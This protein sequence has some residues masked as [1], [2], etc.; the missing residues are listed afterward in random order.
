MRD[1]AGGQGGGDPGREARDA[2]AHAALLHRLALHHGTALAA[3]AAAGARTTGG[4]L[5][6][7]LPDLAG[8][9]AAADLA[10]FARDATERMVLCLETLWQRGNHA[11]DRGADGLKPLLAF[12]FDVVLDGRSLPRPTN[13]ALVLIRPPEGFPPTRPGGRPW[14]IIDPRAGHGSG[15]GGSKAESEVGAALRDGHPVYFVIFHPDPAPDQTLADVC[16]AEARFLAEIRARHPGA[17]PPLVT[18]NCQGGWA[19]MILAATHP[20]L[21]GPVVV[22]GAPVS[23]WAGEVGRNPFRYLGGVAGGAV[24]ALLLAD[25]GAGRFD[26]AVLVRN[27][28]LLNPAR[29]L[30]RKVWELYADDA[31]AE[32]FL[33]FER[34]WSGFYFM[35][36]REIRWIVENLFIGNRLAR[37]EAVLDD[38]TPVDLRRIAVPVIVFASHGDNI[39][40]PQQALNWIADLYPRT[41]ELRAAGKVIIFTLHDTVG[42]LGIFVSAEI[43]ATEHREITSV[44]KT[45]EALA[46]GLYEML[47]ERTAAGFRVRFEAREIADILAHDDGRGDEAAFAA[48]AEYSDWATKTYEL[49]VRPALRRAVT[50]EVAEALRAAHPLRQELL[51]FSRRNPFLEGID[52][53]ARDVRAVRKPSAP[54]NPFRRLETLWA[55]KVARGLDLA[56]DVRDA[57]I[58][59][60][61]HAVWGAPA[62]RAWGEGRHAPAARAPEAAPPDPEALAREAGQGGYPEAI[63]RML[64]LLARARGTVRRDRLDRSNAML[65][66]RPPFDTMTEPQRAAM[67]RRQT[68]I[69]DFAGEAAV[70]TLPLL[71]RDDV[72]RIRALDLALDIAGPVEDMSP[73]T[74]AMMRRIQAVLRLMARGWH[75]PGLAPA[76]EPS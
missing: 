5:A 50:P 45:I 60:A 55:D 32:R 64:I 63:L 13:Y 11:L 26:G 74:L 73:P 65:H 33:A 46:P 68:R 66:A 24:P 2:A 21:C 51:L 52:T 76:G 3:S 35:T 71:L 8:P 25:L 53:L 28:E 20:D 70:T 59:I 12:D 41:E 49:M 14:V 18:G 69:V 22:A 75:E 10:A 4:A 38:G 7:I 23:T 37:G 43:G 62:L 58:E 48:V 34:W 61:F 54:D 39:T 1:G 9:R 36:E 72:D 57:A 17:P 40:P 27:F 29:T 56:R 15:I 16:A 44:V 67:I 42:H 47:I 31:G 6:A 19:A 30:F